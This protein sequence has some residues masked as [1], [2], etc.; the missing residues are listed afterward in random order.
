[1][2]ARL[3][4]RNELIKLESLPVEREFRRIRSERREIWPVPSPAGAVT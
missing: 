1:M 4:I 3:R 2:R